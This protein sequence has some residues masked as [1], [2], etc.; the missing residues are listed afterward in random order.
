MSNF[1]SPF[2]MSVSVARPV[3]IAALLGTAMLAATP[4]AARADTATGAAIQLAQAAAPE[5]GAAA[6]ATRT[7][8]ET[9]EQRI[10]DL[11]AALK[12]TPAEE[13]KWNEVAQAMRENAA[14]MDKLIADTRP[15]PRRA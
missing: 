9:V 10:T 6:R 1:I 5:S 14:A 13:S 7:K 3:A 2:A 4:T 12:I 8:G 11:H 15:C